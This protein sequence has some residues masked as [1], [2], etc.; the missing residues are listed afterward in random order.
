MREAI[1]T[2]DDR[3]LAEIGLTEVVAVAR[4]AGLRD[5]TE[6]GP[7]GIQQVH[8]EEPIPE[9]EL[10][11]LDPIEWWERLDESSGGVTYLWELDADCGECP[12]G[13]HSTA[14]EIAD[15]HERG[16]SLSLIGSQNEI[17]RSVAGMT[18]AGMSVTLERLT[19]YDG[20]RTTTDILTERQR[21]VVRTAY[22]MGYY[23]VPR[24]SSTEDVAERVGL[25]PSTVAEHLQRAEQNLLGEILVT[26]P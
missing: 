24:S 22:S 5:V 11:R 21:E 4:A 1:V 20:P 19:E 15:T 12:V 10:E 14:Y 18:D 9:A 23:E 2:V 17:R 25:D 26:A 3:Q 7:D 6:L 8:V 13:E 16:F